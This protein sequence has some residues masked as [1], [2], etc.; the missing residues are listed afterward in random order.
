MLQINKLQPITNWL[1]NNGWIFYK[2]Q[3][4]VLEYSVKNFDVLLIA[5]TGGG[6]TL[7]GFLPSIYDLSDK[8]K[9]SK[10]HTLYISPLKALAVDVHRNLIKPI[11]EQGMN[12]SIETRTGDTSYLKR[13]RQK[14]NPPDMLMTTPES[15]A[16]MMS[17][18]NSEIYFKKLKSD[19]SPTTSCFTNF[20]CGSQNRI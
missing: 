1:H 13:K 8:K 11:T 3:L 20:T 9:E 12:I 6:K 4:E 10:L 19:F 2:H 15:F 18:S 17:D 7:G 14:N 16:L 5:P